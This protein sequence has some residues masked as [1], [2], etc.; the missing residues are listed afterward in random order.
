MLVYSALHKG[1]YWQD[2]IWWQSGESFR[3]FSGDLHLQELPFEYYIIS[4]VKNLKLEVPCE[5]LVIWA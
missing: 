3:I 2:T 1:L 5:T 4:E